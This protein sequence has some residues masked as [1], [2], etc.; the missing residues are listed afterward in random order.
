MMEYK[1]A[2]KNLLGN[3]SR[4]GDCLLWK[5]SL[6]ESGYGH[7]S[8]KGRQISVHCL[9]YIIEN[10]TYEKHLVIRHKCRNRHCIAPEHLET[11]TLVDNAKDRVRDS[12]APIGD[13]H[14]EAITNG[15]TAVEI[16]KSKGENMTQRERA[17]KFG[18]SLGI[19]KDI[20][21]G[22]TWNHVTGDIRRR[23]KS[24]V[25]RTK[26]MEKVFKD[27]R[28]RVRDNAEQVFDNER[29]EEDHILNE[30]WIWKLAKD[31][32]G[33]GKAHFMG[34]STS[35]HKLSWQC[36][37][38]KLV[39]EGLVVR[40]K[41]VKRPDCINPDH[42]ELGTR[43]DNAQ[44]RIRDSTQ[45]MGENHPMAKISREKALEILNSEKV[46]TQYERAVK[47]GVPL[48]TLR[49]IEKGYAWKCLRVP[50]DHI[51]PNMIAEA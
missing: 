22:R 9:S 32:K 3:S 14:P 43:A 34:K 6:D 38:N 11:G 31:D 23:K 29:D 21:R 40:H 36:F 47:F 51:P 2:N 30:H 33:Y 15:K 20:D 42:L 35:A 46:G 17:E 4:E 13:N 8:F 28:E 27:G 16:Y 50:I 45:L 49:T 7:T 39:P 24:N 18:V 25:D 19:V 10:G 26:N 5:G 37:N 1:L 41:C 48:S 12:T 44:D